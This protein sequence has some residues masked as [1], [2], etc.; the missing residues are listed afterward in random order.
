MT[1]VLEHQPPIIWPNFRIKTEVACGLVGYRKAASWLKFRVCKRGHDIRVKRAGTF[2]QICIDQNRFIEVRYHKDGRDVTFSCPWP[3]SAIHFLAS[4]RHCRHPGCDHRCA[5]MLC[6]HEDRAV[7]LL[8]LLV[9][10][11]A[12]LGKQMSRISHGLL[13]G[14]G[15]SMPDPRTSFVR[16]R[17][18][19]G[20][21]AF[22]GVK[23][24]YIYSYCI[25]VI[26]SCLCVLF[27]CA[28]K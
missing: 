21:G 1:F 6:D 16:I 26:V 2:S 14:S 3:F 11:P 4:H 5:P 13:S 15:V 7:G 23:L 28:T 18:V 12:L 20:F 17:A 10:L 22:F 8:V 24:T 9:L 25:V 19:S 27:M